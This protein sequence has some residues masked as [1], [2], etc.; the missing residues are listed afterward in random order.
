MRKFRNRDA[1]RVRRLAK[2]LATLE[3]EAALA[4]PAPRRALRASLSVAP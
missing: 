2:A 3:R 4:R 1:R